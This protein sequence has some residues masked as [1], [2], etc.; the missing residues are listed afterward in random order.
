MIS[1]RRRRRVLLCFRDSTLSR[2][3][4][5]RYVFLHKYKSLR[6]KCF[7]CC[8]WQIWDQEI[9][10]FEII[11]VFASCLSTWMEVLIHRWAR[12]FLP[13]YFS[14]KNSC[15][16]C[17]S[18]FVF[19][20]KLMKK[21]DS[22][23]TVAIDVFLDQTS[24]RLSMFFFIKPY[25]RP[26]KTQNRFSFRAHLF[27]KSLFRFQCWNIFFHIKTRCLPKHNHCHWC[28]FFPCWS[29][30]RENATTIH[31]CRIR[32]VFWLTAARLLENRNLITKSLLHVE[33]GED[34]KS[35]VILAKSYFFYSLHV[36]CF[37]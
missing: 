7:R 29:I 34:Y 6:I 24:S 31:A 35:H 11:T 37:V 33:G 14:P 27:W 36:F 28:S 16:S 22:I 8:K 21:S 13:S 18:D 30:L 23:R 20:S 19:S 32:L 25:S 1:S 5:W 10:I 2:H 4:H 12:S 15:R 9:M 3:A 17:L 26:W